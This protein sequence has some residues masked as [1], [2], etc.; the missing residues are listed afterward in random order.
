[1]ILWL[2]NPRWLPLHL[3]TG[4]VFL[5]VLCTFALQ[6]VAYQWDFHAVWQ[7]RAKFAAGLGRTV[8]LASASLLLSS[9][10]GVLTALLRRS[11]WMPLR[12][13]AI[14]YTELIRSTP[15]LVQILLLF[16]GVANAAGL[17]NRFVAGVLILSLFAGAYIS[18]IVRAGIEG[19]PQTQ[20]ESAR[21]LGFT[22]LQTYRF[23]ILPQALRQILPP[24]TGQFISLIKDSSLLSIIGVQELTQS[25][26]E[27]NSY[28]YSTLESYLPLA[29]GYLLLTFPLSMLAH[30]L[31]QRMRY[32]S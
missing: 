25:A 22:P 23:V 28:T 9:A 27:I 11:G 30:R 19:I 12:A 13:L 24:M 5:T 14:L 2:K 1:M 6:S 18:E 20:L 15:L 10:F 26:Q 21:S 4:G 16:Y 17:Q 31:E 3:L 29:L 32:G 7:Y 8:G